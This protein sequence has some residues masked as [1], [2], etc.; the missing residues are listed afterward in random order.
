MAGRRRMGDMAYIQARLEGT[1]PWVL[2]PKQRW[3]LA[4]AKRGLPNPA[5]RLVLALYGH[6]DSGGYWEKKFN[7][8]ARKGG[9]RPIEYWPSCFFHPELRLVLVVYVDDFKMSGP[10]A[11]LGKGWATLRGDIKMGDPEPLGKYLGCEHQLLEADA[12]SKIAYAAQI[13]LTS[14]SMGTC[15]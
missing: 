4:W 12:L 13:P 15:L 1:E 7:R 8:T 2:L 14:H 3:P 6:P 11:N 5:C 10:L 9:W